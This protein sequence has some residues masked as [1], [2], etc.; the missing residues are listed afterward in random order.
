[1]ES[2]V[3][4][5]PLTSILLRQIISAQQEP[6]LPP[7][8]GHGTVSDK[9]LEQQYHVQL[10]K[11]SMESAVLPM[12]LT[13]TLLRPLDFVLQ[14]PLRLQE[15][16]HGTVSDKILEQQYHVRLISRLMELAGRLITRLIII[17]VVLL[18]LILFVLLEP[19]QPQPSQDKEIQYLGLVLE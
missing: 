14:E 1:M 7:E 16:G 18:V 17:I 5:M 11:K 12:P 2:A 4:P 3:L 9:I 10:F 19:I 15:P 13:S 6:L 8:P